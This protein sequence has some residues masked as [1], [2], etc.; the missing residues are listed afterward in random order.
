LLEDSDILD[1]KVVPTVISIQAVETFR[2]DTAVITHKKGATDKHG[3]ANTAVQAIRE[4]P[5]FCYTAV[6]KAGDCK[7][8]SPSIEIGVGDSGRRNFGRYPSNC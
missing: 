5:P 1:F 3:W 7:R 4:N 8:C 2:P 6:V